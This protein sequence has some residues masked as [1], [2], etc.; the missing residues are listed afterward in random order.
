MLKTIPLKNDKKIYFW[1]ILSIISGFLSLLIVVPNLTNDIELYGIYSLCISFTLY[2]SYA[3][4]GFLNSGQKYAAE[5][6]AT[7]K[8]KDEVQTLGFTT[9][10][11]LLMMFPFTI[12]MFVCYLNP[13]L[14]ISNL[15]GY[16][17]NFYNFC[18]ELKINNMLKGQI[19]FNI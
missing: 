11:L 2:L 14:L 7:G 3:D 1:K 9:A 17:N 13:G 12:A 6:Y 8:R 18:F 4:I 5:A 10:I 16:F 15:S 19:N